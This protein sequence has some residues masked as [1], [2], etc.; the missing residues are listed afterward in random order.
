MV[1][2]PPRPS[3]VMSR[4]VDTPWNPATTG[5]FPAARASRS[6][7]ARTSRILA[8][9]WSVSVMIPAWLPVNDA[10][11]TPR[12]ASAMHEQGHG[13]PLAG[14]DQHVVL[15]GRLDALTASARRIR[16]SVVLPMALTTAT[17]SVAL[18]PGPGDVIG[19]GADPV[20]VADRG[21]T[22]FL[23]DQWHRNELLAPR[24]ATGPP[25]RRRSNGAARGD[26]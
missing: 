15:A 14:A 26:G 22:E 7:S 6:R 11:S 23:D 8:R 25:E 18:A 2:D 16:S 17:T 13:D 3:V 1:S 20:G 9:V 12:S 21:P 5:T 4:S 10:A 24:V 19:H